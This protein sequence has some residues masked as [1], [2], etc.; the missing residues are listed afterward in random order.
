[1]ETTQANRWITHIDW[2]LIR[3]RNWRTPKGIRISATL[4]EAS[5]FGM[6][7]KPSNAPQLEW[8][9]E[10]EQPTHQ[11]ASCPERIAPHDSHRSFGSIDNCFGCG[12]YYRFEKGELWEVMSFEVAFFRLGRESSLKSEHEDR[13]N[14][15]NLLVNYIWMGEEFC[16]NVL[17]DDCSTLI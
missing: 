13:G 8:L 2:Q 16:G 12:L 4:S 7:R 3:K 15:P 5:K 14:S 1:M 6:S 10:A 11:E 17:W 9:F